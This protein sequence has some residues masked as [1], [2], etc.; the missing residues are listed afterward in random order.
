MSV[1]RRG[2][3]SPLAGRERAGLVSDAEVDRAIE[4]SELNEAFHRKGYLVADAVLMQREQNAHADERIA[5][6][7][8]AW[9]VDKLTLTPASSISPSWMTPTLDGRRASPTG[10]IA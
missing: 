8:G 9:S 2:D 5:V 10:A 3:V 4:R 1:V 6:V 7:V